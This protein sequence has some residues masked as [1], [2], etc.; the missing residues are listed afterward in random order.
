MQLRV[1][2][3][4]FLRTDHGTIMSPHHLMDGV[5][6]R[7]RSR[8]SCD[9]AAIVLDATGITYKILN[10]EGECLIIVRT[11][12]L[13][14]SR[15]ELA[16]YSLENHKKVKQQNFPQPASKGFY[17]VLLFAA[18]L[19]LIYIFQYD[20]T[21]NDRLIKLG[22]ANAG[23][24]QQG[25]WWRAM[26]ALTLHSDIAHLIGNIGFGSLFGFS[27]SQILGP[28]LAWFSILLAGTLGN[29]ISAFI[30]RPSH[31]AIGA[32]TAVF[33]AL[34]IM[35]AHTWSKGRLNPQTQPGMRRWLPIMG[36][37]ALLSFLGGPG[38]LVDV[39][40]HVTGFLAGI[41]FGFVFGSLENRLKL[42]YR[43]QIILGITTGCLVALAW[44]AAI[45]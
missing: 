10:A 2:D 14:R 22:N 20:K 11:E 25:E 15:E 21:I 18:L 13:A 24:I 44:L 5:A 26:T 3:P 19:T 35:A 7:S 34:G 16:L 17:G 39:V 28:G 33:A 42:E 43:H 37:V 6:F 23:L 1:G 12:D 30:Q 41:V 4:L 36:G 9:E 29:L 45:D 31:S 32:S 38:L 40:S 27:A 8:A